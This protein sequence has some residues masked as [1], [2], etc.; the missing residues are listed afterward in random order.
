MVEQA[1]GIVHGPLP[2]K[3]SLPQRLTMLLHVGESHVI[4]P[5]AQLDLEL[6]DGGL[7]VGIGLRVRIRNEH[8]V[9]GGAVS[10]LQH[11]GPEHDQVLAEK[12]NVRGQLFKLLRQ[13][14]P[15]YLVVSA[16]NPIAASEVSV[17]DDCGK[18]VRQRWMPSQR[19]PG[20]RNWITLLIVL[21]L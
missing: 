20:P 5:G 6:V 18:Q 15:L 3:E 10:P 8:P 7:G 19:I 17:Q 13:L 4:V 1:A 11:D 2:E 16:L 21:H 12:L 14:P 9:D